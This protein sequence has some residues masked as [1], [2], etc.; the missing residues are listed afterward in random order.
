MEY[1]LFFLHSSFSV[2]LDC[3]HVLAIVKNVAINMRMQVF[4]KVNVFVI[5]DKYL[6]VKL[7]DYM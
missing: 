1:F 6:E 3:F 2:H 4:F 7:L 5:S